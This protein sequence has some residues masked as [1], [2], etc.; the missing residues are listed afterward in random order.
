MRV[1]GHTYQKLPHRQA[2]KDRRQTS[3]R[4]LTPFLN[5]GR[6]AGIRP[7]AVTGSLITIITFT[8]PAVETAG[9][10]NKVRLRGLVEKYQSAQADFV[11]VA[12]GFNRWDEVIPAYDGKCDNIYARISNGIRPTAGGPPEPPQLPHP[13]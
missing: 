5:P 7:T 3:Q 11:W 1:W 13:P 8:V 12:R 10:T 6:I 4:L 9:N 2:R